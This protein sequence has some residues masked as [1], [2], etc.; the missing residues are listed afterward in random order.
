MQYPV[1]VEQ[2]NGFWRAVIP[3]LAGLSAEG[4]SLDDALQNARQAAE[5]YLANVVMTT[6]EIGTTQLRKPGRQNGGIQRHREAIERE[7]AIAA[8]LNSLEAENQLGSLQSIIRAAADCR[9]DTESE[10]FKE[11][12]AELDAEKERQRAEAEREADAT[13]V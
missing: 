1:I 7:F 5:A 11:Y 6:I 12:E 9:I 10:M 2:T 13:A 4:A 3:A 8:E